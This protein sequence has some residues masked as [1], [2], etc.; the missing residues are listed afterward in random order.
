MGIDYTQ[1]KF[2][3]AINAL[4]SGTGRIQERL[5]S[6]GRS[7]VI[8]QHHGADDAAFVKQPE[9]QRR[10]DQV[11]DRLTSTPARGDEGTIRA[12]AHALTD[13]EGREIA[14]EIF[15]LFC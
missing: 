1:Q 14:N 15:S 10:F 5:E 3:E 9:L 2:W 13:D 11:M 8:L 12:S 4:V 7:L 6:A